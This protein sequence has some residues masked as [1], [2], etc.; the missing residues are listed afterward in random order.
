MIDAAYAQV[1]KTLG[2]PTH[3]YLVASDGKL[4]DAQAGMESQAGALV[5]ALAGVDLVSGAGMLDVLLCQSPEKLVLDA[6]AI[7]SAQR[8]VRGIATPTDTL[9]TAAFA[10]AG[11][12]GRFL[13]L[14]ETRR[15][16]R[17]EQHLPGP[18]IDRASHRAWLES[19]GL[20]AFGRARVRADELVAAHRRPDLDLAV[21]RELVGIVRRESVA[22]GA[23]TLPGVPA[24]VLARA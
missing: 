4:A 7:G 10:A 8:L 18:V 1:G 12:D 13:E 23:T 6:E 17:T 14:S 21:E 16:F 15:L 3:C 22:A 11:P 20:D 2:L 19:G 24:E 9:A 5:A